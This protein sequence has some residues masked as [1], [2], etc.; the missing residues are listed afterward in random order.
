[1]WAQEDGG[2]MWSLMCGLDVLVDCFPGGEV[3]RGWL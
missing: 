1:M 3:W 2:G